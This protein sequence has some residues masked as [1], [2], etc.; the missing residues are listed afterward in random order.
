MK[1]S[2]DD[3]SRGICPMTNGCHRLA[4]RCGRLSLGFGSNCSIVFQV[5]G[6]KVTC[7]F[8]KG[9]P[10][11]SSLVM[12]SRRTSF[13]LTSSPTIVLPRAAGFAT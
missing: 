12:I 6:R 8:Y 3:A 1:A 13:G 4:S 10:R 2:A 5:C 11:R 9:L 7:H